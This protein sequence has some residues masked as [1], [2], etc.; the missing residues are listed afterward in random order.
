MI[1]GRNPR[2]AVNALVK[3]FGASKANAA[4]LVSTE[5]AFFASEAQKD[6]FNFWEVEEFEI[7]GT[8]DSITC[9]TCGAMDTTHLPMSQFE[10]GVTAP[11]FHP[12]CRCCTCPWIPDDVG[13]RIARGVDGKPEYVPTNMS[14]EQWNEK[15]VKPTEDARKSGIIDSDSISMFTSGGLGALNPDSIE[16]QNHAD[17]YYE[18]IRKR[19]MMLSRLLKT[20]G[21]LKKTYDL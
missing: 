5:S 19:K 13:E 9:Q 1:L 4:R 15:Y 6:A 20:R 11:P 18:E 14:Y 16:A 21:F 10:S 3:K 2:E 17:L 8:L 7:V 12:C